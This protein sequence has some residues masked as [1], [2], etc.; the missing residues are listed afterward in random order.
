[1]NHFFLNLDF[2]TVTHLDCLKQ[3]WR[4]LIETMSFFKSSQ[5]SLFTNTLNV[6]KIRI[7]GARLL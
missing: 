4:Q 7:H 6:S 1:M 3:L 2:T 5:L